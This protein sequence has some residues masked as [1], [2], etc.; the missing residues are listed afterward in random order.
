LFPC[1]SL[2]HSGPGGSIVPE[3]GFRKRKRA[4]LAPLETRE[5]TALML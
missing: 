3:T 2:R 5:E 1:L 4:P